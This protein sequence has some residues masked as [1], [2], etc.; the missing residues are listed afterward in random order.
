MKALFPKF[1]RKAGY[2]TLGLAVV[3][4]FIAWNLELLT[5]DNFSVFKASIKLIL[6]AGAFLL[7]FAKRGEENKEIETYRGRSILYGLFLTWIYLFA[8][9]MYHI[10]IQDISYVDSSSFLTFLILSNV[11]FE[12]FTILQK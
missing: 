11:C 4:P 1:C 9:M 3:F 12:F 6:I 5:D 2:T 7:L 10:I 8:E